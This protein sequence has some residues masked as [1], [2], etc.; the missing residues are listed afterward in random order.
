MLRIIMIFVFVVSIS[1][2]CRA[3]DNPASSTEVQN[4]EVIRVKEGSADA[5]QKT[6]IEVKSIEPQ[7]TMQEDSME[8]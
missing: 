4:P 3:E 6:K 7:E 1:V 5:V 8:V 2:F